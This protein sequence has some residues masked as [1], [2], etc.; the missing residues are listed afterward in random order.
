MGEPVPAPG[1]SEHRTGK[2]EIDHAVALVDVARDVEHA[3]GSGNRLLVVELEAGLPH[4]LGRAEDIRTA[5]ADAGND[6]LDRLVERVRRVAG[7][8]EVRRPARARALEDE[9]DIP[10]LFLE[11]VSEEQ[12]VE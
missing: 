11:F 7:L 5:A 9:G 1:A 12:A 3:G 8:G 4:V 10:V 6:I 2:S